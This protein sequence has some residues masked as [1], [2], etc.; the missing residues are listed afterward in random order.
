MTDIIPLL[1]RGALVSQDPKAFEDVH[2]LEAAEL[3]ALR[4]EVSHKWRQPR[5]LYFTVILC[6]IGA[7]VQ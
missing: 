5:A 1:Q 4:N 7:C 6:S 3:D 2:E